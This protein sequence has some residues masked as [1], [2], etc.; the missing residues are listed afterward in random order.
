[1]TVGKYKAALAGLVVMLAVSCS[2]A[3]AHSARTACRDFRRWSAA[4][5]ASTSTPTGNGVHALAMAV[6]EAPPG[7]LHH[8]LFLLLKN[9]TEANVFKGSNGI[10]V[11]AGGWGDVL[12]YRYVVKVDC[13]TVH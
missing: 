1:M 2:S 7:A 8:D 11:G 12:G 9:V 13:S 10:L 5:D 6:S 4:V 3:P